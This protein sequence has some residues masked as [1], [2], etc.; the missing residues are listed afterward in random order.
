[1]IQLPWWFTVKAPRFSFA[2]LMNSVFSS[3]RIVIRSGLNLFSVLAL[4]LSASQDMQ[5]ETSTDCYSWNVYR[6]FF[7]DNLSKQEV[8]WGNTFIRET[9]LLQHCYL[10]NRRL[11]L[12]LSNISMYILQTVPYTFPEILTRRIC[13]TIKGVFRM[14]SVRFGGGIVSIL[15]VNQVFESLNC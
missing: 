9:F 2:S 7:L 11:T 14:W 4:F 3:V 12:L 10:Y 1:M 6:T 8:K 13:L 5:K 15:K